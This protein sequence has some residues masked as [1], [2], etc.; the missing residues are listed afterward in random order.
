MADLTAQVHKQ[1]QQLM[2]SKL[3]QGVN[4]KGK[5]DKLEQLLQ[6]KDN[7]VLVM[8]KVRQS[9]SWTHLLSACRLSC[10]SRARSCWSVLSNPPPTFSVAPVIL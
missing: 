9:T 7:E 8:R 2:R 3:L 4:G 6:E 5:Y 10:P 1:R